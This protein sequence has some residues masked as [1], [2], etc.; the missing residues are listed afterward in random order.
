MTPLPESVLHTSIQ[1]TL[2]DVAKAKSR[3]RSVTLEIQ[4]ICE[5]RIVSEIPYRSGN[6]PAERICNHCRLIEEGSH[7]SGGKTWSRHDFGKSELGNVTGRIIQ[8]ITSDEFYKMR[9][10]V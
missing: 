3:L 1:S 10:P 5:H 7:W 4:N 8:T 9:I 2:K 6:L